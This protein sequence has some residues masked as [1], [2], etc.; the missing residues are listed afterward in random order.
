LATAT[1]SGRRASPRRCLVGHIA[2]RTSRVT[3]PHDA[4]AGVRSA[5][6]KDRRAVT[7]FRTYSDAVDL[8]VRG[9]PY[10]ALVRNRRNEAAK[11][12]GLV[13]T[14][15]IAVGQ[16]EL[17][18]VDWVDESGHYLKVH[19]VNGGI[20]TLTVEESF[21]YQAGDVLW[22]WQEN[23]QAL[24]LAAPAAAWPDVPWIGVVKLITPN[25]RLVVDIG[26]RFVEVD[27]NG[28][29]IETGYTVRGVD[30]RV[31]GVLSRSPIKYIDLPSDEDS[32]ADDYKVDTRGL[33]FNEFGGYAHVVQRARELVELPLSKPELLQ[34]INARTIK[35][36]VFTGPPGTGKTL[37]ARIVA[38]V[39][40]ADCFLISGPEIITKWYGDR[41]RLLRDIFR[42]ASESSRSV[43][44]MMSWTVSLDSE[45]TTLTRRRNGSLPRC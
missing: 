30:E 33:S 39:S 44:V 18:K 19:F 3:S 14:D 13:Q 38:S 7:R 5:F 23:E 11:D 1:R 27:N 36:V 32:S 20:T 15:Y 29:Q 41:E 42:R 31:T 45:L 43:I 35:G 24:T 4:S 17:V 34:R 2:H 21:A 16:R 10:T 40:G 37:L 12:S 28:G 9:G 26:S 8:T 22:L 6:G 25:D